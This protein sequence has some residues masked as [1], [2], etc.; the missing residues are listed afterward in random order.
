MTVLHFGRLSS[1]SSMSRS[2]RRPLRRSNSMTTADGTP[3]VHSSTGELLE[4]RRIWSIHRARGQPGYALVDP[5]LQLGPGGW[6]TNRQIDMPV[7]I[8]HF[9]RRWYL[10]L[11][12]CPQT[13]LGTSNPMPTIWLALVLWILATPLRNRQSCW[14]DGRVV[15]V[16]RWSACTRTELSKLCLR[17]E[18]HVLFWLT[19]YSACTNTVKCRRESIVI[20]GWGRLEIQRNC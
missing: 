15:E 17:L 11:L 6:P 9:G 2:R 10:W 1:S 19:L 7:K 4:S 18:R 3:P 12:L 20:N 16:L 13:P 14:T 5:A 8:L